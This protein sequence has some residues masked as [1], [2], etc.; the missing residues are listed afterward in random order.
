MWIRL[1]TV[2]WFFQAEGGLSPP[3]RFFNITLVTNS[4]ETVMFPGF[5]FY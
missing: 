4:L 5:C 1:R 2:E 3:E